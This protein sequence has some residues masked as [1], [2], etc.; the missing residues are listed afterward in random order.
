MTAL[1]KWAELRKELS[2]PAIGSNHH[3]RKLALSL[4]DELEGEAGRIKELESQRQLAFM[5]SNRWAEKFREAENSNA[6]Q[7]G[8]IAKQEKW[9]KDVEATMIAATDRAEAAEKQNDELRLKNRLL[10]NADRDIA[11]LRQRIAELET[12]KVKLPDG[13]AI[14]PGHPINEGER[15]V[16]IPK[17]DGPWFSRFDVEHA[18]R[19]AGINMRLEGNE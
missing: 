15:S 18:L 2:N 1:N 14:R 16:M 7:K 8:I 6:E 9:I 17:A 5:A 4:L 13:Y 11:A 19:T 10:D 12:R 3:L